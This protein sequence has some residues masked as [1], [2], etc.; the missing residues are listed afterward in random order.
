MI[1]VAKTQSQEGNDNLTF[2]FDLWTTQRVF[3][4]LHKNA[5]YTLTSY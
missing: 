1:F 3:R 2:E 5:S 4:K